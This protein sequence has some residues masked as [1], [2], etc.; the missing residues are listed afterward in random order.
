MNTPDVY[1][2]PSSVHFRFRRAVDRVT[3]DAEAP[4]RVRGAVYDSRPPPQRRDTKLASDALKDWR[5]AG[6]SRLDELERVHSDATGPGPGRRW[7]TEQLNRSLFVALV[8]QFQTYC[9]NLHDEAVDLHVN[10]ANA[11][12]AELLHALLTQ[13]RKLDIQTPRP[14]VLGGDFGRLGFSVLEAMRAVGPREEQDLDRLDVLVDFR[15]AIG[16]GNE[17]EVSALVGRG[18]IRATKNVY[19]RYRRTLERVAGTIDGVVAAK[20]ADVLNIPRP[21]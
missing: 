18:E 13:G 3:P 20:M 14:S 16:H 10:H 6:L 2:R 17:T 12:Q 1:S 19:H 7:G 9:R 5:S 15:N 8:A 21:W 4:A 11:H